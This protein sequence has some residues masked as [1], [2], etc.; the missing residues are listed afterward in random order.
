LIGAGALVLAMACSRDATVAARPKEAP[1]VAPTA[2]PSLPPS[3]SPPPGGE[4]F[5]AD[6]RLLFRVVACAGDAPL[7]ASMDP[8]VVDEHC[9][10]LV[11]RLEA[12]RRDYLSRVTSFFADRRPPDLPPTVVY[13][14]GGGDLLSALATYPA[15]RDYTTLSL[16]HVG[17]PRRI[18]DMDSTRLRQS[19][20]QVERRIRGLFAYAESTS[21]NLMQLQRGDIPGQLAFFLVALAAHGYEPVGLRYFSLEPNGE[22]RY[23]TG[24]EIIADEGKRARRLNA[25]W[26][27]PDFSEVFS[28]AELV[29]KP[30]GPAGASALRVHRH[31]AANLADGQLRGSPALHYLEAKGKVAAMTKAAS[32]LLWAEGFSEIRKYLVGHMV[33]D[34]TG[35]PPSLLSKNGFLIE[36]YGRYRG[37]FLAAR[38]SVAE[39]YKKLWDEQP[40]RELNFRYGYPDASGSNHLMIVRQGLP[41]A[42]SPSGSLSSGQA[43]A[44]R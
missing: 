42:P 44:S 16:E 33:S 35:L 12:Y 8:A 18:R 13:P 40:A 24:E 34:S 37:P 6:A 41:P 7:P 38:H 11:P 5:G 20:R 1:T 17:D 29:F 15:A 32:Y 26:V 31:L 39:E 21:E 2:V 19:L 3:A 28:N 30:A 14:F 23:A 36:T 22:I 4:E 9:R 43:G 10:W 25:L 27:S